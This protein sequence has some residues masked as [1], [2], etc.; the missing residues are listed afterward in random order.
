M[1]N[2]RHTLIIITIAA[3]AAAEPRPAM[4]EDVPAT[5]NTEK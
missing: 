1:R 2:I 3:L 4:V 5:K